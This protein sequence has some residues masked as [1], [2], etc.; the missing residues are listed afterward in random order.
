MTEAATAAKQT[1]EI[2]SFNRF[3]LE[4]RDKKG[5]QER[6]NDE[7]DFMTEV[8]LTDI[9]QTLDSMLAK[10]SRLLIQMQQT[11]KR[12]KAKCVLFLVEPS[13]IEYCAYSVVQAQHYITENWVHSSYWWRYQL[14]CVIGKQSET[15]CDQPLTKA[16]ISLIGIRLQE[17]CEWSLKQLDNL[18][19]SDW[20]RM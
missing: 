7:T 11:M 12:Y 16:V 14:A 17:V 1:A 13:G 6:L 8:H 20:E 2:I 3:D 10:K 15:V 4:R 18:E 19:S 9:N 5:R